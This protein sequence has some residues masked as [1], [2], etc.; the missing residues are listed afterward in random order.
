MYGWK[1]ITE[2]PAE[3]GWYEGWFGNGTEVDFLRD[4]VWFSN[5]KFWRNGHRGELTQTGISA[6]THW[7]PYLPP[8]ED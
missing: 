3:R 8:P 4:D 1:K 2:P 5:G 6:L 7:A